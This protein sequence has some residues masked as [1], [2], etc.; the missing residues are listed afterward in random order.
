MAKEGSVAPK[1]RVNIVYRPATGDAKEEVELPLKT[2]IV[3]D[4][5]LRDDETPVEDRK[6]IN[7]DKDNLDDVLKAQN[8]RLQTSVKSSLSDDPEAQMSLDLDFKSMKDFDPD[9]VIEKVPEL[10]KLLDLREA[11][12]ALK[13]PLGNVP[14]FRKRIQE[15]VQDEGARARLLKELDIKE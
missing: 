2:L 14:N 7:V 8:I 3:G 6:T 5:T 11:L 13:G 10:K 12:K 4:F 15:L 1:E 9:A